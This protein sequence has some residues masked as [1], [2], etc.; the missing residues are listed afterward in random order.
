MNPLCGTLIHWRHSYKRLISL[1]LL[2]L[3]VVAQLLQEEDAYSTNGG[4]MKKILSVLFALLMATTGFAAENNNAMA[5]LKKALL[6]ENEG[7]KNSGLVVLVK[8]KSEQPDRDYGPFNTIL[9]QLAQDSANPAIR[10]NANLAFTYLN[11]PVLSSEFKV[12]SSENPN[13]VFR[14][15]AVTLEKDLLLYTD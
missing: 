3:I 1:F 10:K 13:A 12:T 7:V 2:L 8:T 6:S 14:E 15:L 4:G 11:S 9:N 5:S